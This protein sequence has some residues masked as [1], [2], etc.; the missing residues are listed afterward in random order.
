VPVS[1]SP[2]TGYAAGLSAKS[3]PAAPDSQVTQAAPR[4]SGIDASTR[5]PIGGVASRQASSIV[6]SGR[7]TFR[8][9]T[10][11]VSADIWRCEWSP[12]RAGRPRW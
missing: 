10:L 4:G 12:G 2:E 6:V 9:Q 11:P 7:H 3:V 8:V 1:Y 5:S